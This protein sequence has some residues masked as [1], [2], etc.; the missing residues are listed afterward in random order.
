MDP[1]PTRNLPGVIEINGERIEYFRKEGNTLTQLRRGTL[2][3]G[4]SN[5]YSTG[6]LIEYIGIS[7]TI[8]YKDE[9]VR[10]A[11]V[12]DGSSLIIP[13]TFVP[14]V[15][16]STVQTG[17]DWTRVTIPDNYGQC[18]EIEVYIAGRKLRKTPLAVYNSLLS[19]DSEQ[20]DTV[21]EA[22]FSVDGVNSEIRLSATPPA[23]TRVEVVRNIG[24][25]WVGDGAMY[26]S[27]NRIPKF[28]REVSTRLPK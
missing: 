18:D 19:Q 7:E 17:N 13:T 6:T 21:L 5:V 4:I 20:G 16:A 25:K 14:K 2:G 9:V 10:D 11:T 27:E 15:N 22:E 26:D 3:T 1:V 23:G 28:I 8:P 12:S 24:K